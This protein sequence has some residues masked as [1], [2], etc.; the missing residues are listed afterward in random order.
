MKSTTKN[1]EP[2]TQSHIGITSGLEVSK[3]PQNYKEIKNVTFLTM[4]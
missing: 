1:A 3:H 4:T 2:L